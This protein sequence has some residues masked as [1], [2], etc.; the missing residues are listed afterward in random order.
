MVQYEAHK[1]AVEDAAENAQEG[2]VQPFPRD[3]IALCDLCK[4]DDPQ[5]RNIRSA[6]SLPHPDDKPVDLSEEDVQALLSKAEEGYQERE[7]AANAP[8]VARFDPITGR[9]LMT[10]NQAAGKV[11][12]PRTTSEE[13]RSPSEAGSTVGGPV[14]IQRP[15]T[16]QKTIQDDKEV[17]GEEA[18]KSERPRPA[19]PSRPQ[20]PTPHRGTGG[21]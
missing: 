16:E 5:I 11:R 12:M 21:K 3:V 9:P 20:S 18:A 7:E 2:R 4:E 17:G 1:K 14:R 6:A 8:P 19:H 15:A 13:V 10:G